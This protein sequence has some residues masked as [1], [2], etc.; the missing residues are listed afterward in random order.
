MLTNLSNKYLEMGKE[1]LTGEY[2]TYKGKRTLITIDSE[3]KELA[4]KIVEAVQTN[5]EVEASYTETSCGQLCLC[6]EF[7][8]FRAD[9]CLLEE[10]GAELYSLTNSS[11]EEFKEVLSLIDT[12]TPV[13]DD[14]G[15]YRVFWKGFEADLWLTHDIFNQIRIHVYQIEDED[16]LE[17]YPEEVTADEISDLDGILATLKEAIEY[18]A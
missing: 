3:D 8:G 9:N 7:E 14:K 12:D 18:F 2:G 4:D 15:Y 1:W 10:N 6:I 11:F 5:D 16:D 17:V 13:P